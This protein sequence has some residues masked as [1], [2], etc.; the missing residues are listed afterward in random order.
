MKAVVTS[1]QLYE[2]PDGDSKPPA[3]IRGLLILIGAAPTAYALNHAL[4]DSS[5][6]TFMQATQKVEGVFTARAEGKTIP[7]DQARGEVTKALQD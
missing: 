4:P 2:A 5:T 3:W 1:K 7:A 6:P